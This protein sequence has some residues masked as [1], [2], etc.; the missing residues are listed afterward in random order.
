MHEEGVAFGGFLGKNAR[1]E[2][3]DGVGQS[4][5]RFS[6]IDGG[7][8]GGVE[9]HVRR[10][11]ADEVARLIGIGEID[12]LAIDSDDGANGGKETFKLAAE[13]TSVANNENARLHR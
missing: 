6:A 1:S 13:L 2:G 5:L 12:G 9:N 11:A 4:H 8:G 7:V 10:R 3:V